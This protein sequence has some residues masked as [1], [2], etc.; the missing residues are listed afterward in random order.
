MEAI[1]AKPSFSE[2][3]DPNNINHVIAYSQLQR[4]G[5]W[6]ERFLPEKIYIE[7]NWQT[8]LAYKM[9]NAWIDYKLDKANSTDPIGSN[10]PV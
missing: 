8:I 1:S 5:M 2:W 10:G 3:F 7:P 6:P 9:A 4:T